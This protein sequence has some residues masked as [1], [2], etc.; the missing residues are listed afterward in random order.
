MWTEANANTTAARI[1]RAAGAGCTL[2][3]RSASS[4][5]DRHSVRRAELA[6]VRG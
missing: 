1:W 3:S 6:Q 2:T 5:P 4:F